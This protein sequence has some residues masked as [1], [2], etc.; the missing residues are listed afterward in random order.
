MLPM[1]H[2]HTAPLAIAIVCVLFPVIAA[3]KGERVKSCSCRSTCYTC[4]QDLYEVGSSYANSKSKCGWCGQAT[5]TDGY[6]VA[7]NDWKS[8]QEKCTSGSVFKKDDPCAPG[9]EAIYIPIIVCAV[10]SFAIC[11]KW[12]MEWRVSIQMKRRMLLIGLLLPIVSL[13]LVHYLHFSK[14]ISAATELPEI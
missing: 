13:F 7:E 14:V 5:A 12:A 2:W 11:N 3:F 6:C 4:L 1:A 8:R 9:P 10:F